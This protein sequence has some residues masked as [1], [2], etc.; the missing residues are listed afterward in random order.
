MGPYFYEVAP[1]ANNILEPGPH[2]KTLYMSNSRAITTDPHI[3]IKIVYLSYLL[4][5]Q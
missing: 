4:P 5:D 2:I 1:C 3:K